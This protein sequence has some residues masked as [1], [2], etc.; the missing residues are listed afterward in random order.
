[1]RPALIVVDPPR[2]DQGLGVGDRFEPMNVQTFVPWGSVEALDES[3]V[4]WLAWPG[5]VDPDAMVISPQI[6]QVP[7]ELGAIVGKQ[8]FWRA[9]QTNETIENIENMFATKSRS[10]LNGQT[11]TTE[12]VDYGQRSE[13][14]SVAQLIVDEVEAP[15]LIR[16]RGP[17]ASFSMHHHLA[18]ARPFGP[19]RQ[20]LFAIQPVDQV[21]ADSPAFTFEQD[22]NTSIAIP[23]PRPSDLLHPL[24]DLGTWVANAGFALG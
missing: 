17:T 13:L 24:P 21:L 19:Q 8:I 5:E 22:V 10:D 15:G 7:S 16:T 12:Y 2:F 1:M 6:N 18:S 20:A 4:G 14:L 11:F 3:V 9:S 23:N